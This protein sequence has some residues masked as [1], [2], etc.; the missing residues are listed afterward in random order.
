MLTYIE[1]SLQAG[2][3]PQFP[4]HLHAGGQVVNRCLTDPILELLKYSLLQQ[5]QVRNKG[6]Q[7]C[8][9]TNATN[10]N[11]LSMCTAR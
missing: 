9:C 7:S 3:L 2:T 1:W 4:V 8:S 5:Q 11:M 6:V 10:I